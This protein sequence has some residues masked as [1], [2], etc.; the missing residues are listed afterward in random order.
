MGYPL[1]RTRY[2]FDIQM[3]GA[4]VKKCATKDGNV[5][6]ISLPIN[7]ARK[8]FV[9]EMDLNDPNKATDDPLFDYDPDKIDDNAL[10]TVSYFRYTENEC[11]A[12][13]HDAP[14]IMFGRR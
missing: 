5:D 12:V 3:T 7:G 9:L 10:Y 6:R 14:P 8:M 4:A 2:T 1:I 11:Y 13:V